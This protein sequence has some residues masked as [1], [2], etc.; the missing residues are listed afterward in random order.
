MTTPDLHRATPGGKPRARALGI[1]FGGR[2]GANNAITD[3]PG[4]EVGYVTLAFSTA[5]PGAFR[6]T[7]TGR[8]GH[9]S[10]ALPRARVAGP[11]AA[12]GRLAWPAP[13]RL[14]RS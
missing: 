11:L 9:R 6:R 12:A 8:D 1:P 3:V 7:T 4:V 2:P 10:P 14:L 13:R 5:S